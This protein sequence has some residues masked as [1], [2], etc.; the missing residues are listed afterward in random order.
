MDTNKCHAKDVRK[1]K[2]T[3]EGTAEV[4]DHLTELL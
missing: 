2:N 1:V 3:V 4:Q